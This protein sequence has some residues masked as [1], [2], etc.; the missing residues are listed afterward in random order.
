VV[1]EKTCDEFVDHVIAWLMPQEDDPKYTFRSC[2]AMPDDAIRPKLGDDFSVTLS[3][4][5]R[6]VLR[7]LGGAEWFLEFI[8]TTGVSQVI[9]RYSM[10]DHSWRREFESALWRAG[11]DVRVCRQMGGASGAR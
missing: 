5:A 7:E 6:E 3:R 8:E 9:G 4:R 1:T 10:G 2:D 11:I